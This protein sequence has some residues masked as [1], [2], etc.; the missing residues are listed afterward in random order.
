VKKWH[1]MKKAKKVKKVEEVKTEEEILAKYGGWIFAAVIVA[2]LGL[3]VFWVYW[4]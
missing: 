2:W 1:E 4:K 3:I